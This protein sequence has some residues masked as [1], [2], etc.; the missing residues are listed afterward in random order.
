MQKKIKKL[1]GSQVELEVTLENKQFQEYYQLAYDDAAKTITIKGFRPGAAPKELVDQ[2][3]DHDKVFH[4]AVQDAVKT[5]LDEIKRENDWSLIDSPRVE[6]TEGDP[7][8]GVTYKATLTLFP[9]VELGNYKKTAKKIF[10]E[11]KEVAVGDEEVA[12]TIDWVRKSRAAVTRVARPSAMGDMVEIDIDT[13]S[14]GKA[15]PN[16]T[17]KNE[18]FI[19]GESQFISGFDKQ[20]EG[21]KEGEA[22]NFSITAPADYWQKNFQGKQLDFSVKI[23]GVYERKVPDLTDEFAA[24]LGPKFK[25]VEDI[26]TNVREG[27]AMEKQEKETEKQ[28]IKLIDEIVKDSQID[29]PTILIERTLDGLAAD[30]KRMVPPE[31]NKNPEALDKEMREKLRERAVQN[32]KGNLVMYKLAQVER[33]EPTK[34]EIEAEAAKAGVDLEK[35]HDYIYNNLQNQ[36]VFAFLEN[37]AKT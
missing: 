22:A 10:S 13:Q 15:V 30:V 23:N 18:R 33:L 25:T 3:I 24:G 28:R 17:F 5:S 2:A 21:K 11:K 12:K 31:E 29:V 35:E 16:S 4:A 37:Q 1:P 27:L 34:E 32:V 8:K 26:K 6:V 14:A 20:L 19:L 9:E 7:E 36:K